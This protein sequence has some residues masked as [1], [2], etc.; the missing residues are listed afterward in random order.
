M[1]LKSR[2]IALC[3]LTCL[4]YIPSVFAELPD[5]PVILDSGPGGC[6]PA[7]EICGDGIDQDC[8]GSDLACPG[9]DADRDGFAQ[10]TDC[11]DNNRKVYPGIS[12]ACAGSCGQGTQTC[13][14]NG[15]FTAC[16]CTPL[17]EAKGGG[18]CYYISALTGNDSNPG[19]FSKPWKSYK[20][21]VSYYNGTPAPPTWQALNPGDVVYFMSG[22]YSYTYDY[23]GTIRAFM[24]RGTSGTAEAPIVLKAYPGAH[25]VLAPAVQAVG[26]YLLQVEHI[27]M[28]GFEIVRAYQSGINFALVKN[29]E[30]RNLWIHDIDGLDNNNIAGLK[31]ES[32]ENVTLHHSLIHDNYDRNNHDSNGEKTINSRN[33]VIFK[34][35]NIRFH[36]NVIFQTPPIDAPKTGA[37][38]A[39]KHSSDVANSIFEV[40]NNIFWNCSM[41]SIG[42]GTYGNR[43]HHN[44]I[45]NSGSIRF[46]DFGGETHHDD[47]IVEKNTVVGGEALKYNPSTTYGPIGNITIRDNVYVDNAS[48]YGN[49][50]GIMTINTYGTDEL[51]DQSIDPAKFILG[52]NCYHN[53][54]TAPKWSV[55]A[56]NGGSRG[57]KGGV[58]DFSTWQSKGMDGSS[59]VVDPQLDA[60]QIPQNAAC[61]SRGWSAP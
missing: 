14:A 11:N 57:V 43:F 47:I 20:N 36:H 39:Y 58:W 51:Y 10:G 45:L 52:T 46:Q 12:V 60:Y 13:Q 42:S 40:D 6:V 56:A 35:G 18:K 21:I 33:I 48:S 3:S 41:Y 9:S 16:S 50:R 17:C 27:I 2:I 34:G 55:Y 23:S 59:A 15:S 30:L 61:Q 44:L 5:A 37:C 54:N 22:I 49:E 31:L 7:T 38:I 24:M 8:N 32:V 19:S 1:N 4:L 25:P 53:P 26:V 28:E 29:F